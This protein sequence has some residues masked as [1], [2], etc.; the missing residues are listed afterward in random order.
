MKII[1]DFEIDCP[2]NCGKRIRK[3]DTKD[4]LKS[5]PNKLYECK[6]CHKKFKIDEFKEH[7][8]NDHDDIILSKFVQ[9][10]RNDSQVEE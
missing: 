6:E 10:Q 7:I 2:L 4:H 5:C 3:G 1:G 9:N 8:K